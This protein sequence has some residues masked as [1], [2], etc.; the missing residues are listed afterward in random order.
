[1][2]YFIGMVALIVGGSTFAATV[3]ARAA[4]GD[5]K[6]YMVT[7]T[8]VAV[9]ANIIFIPWFWLSVRRFLS[10]Q[11]KMKESYDKGMAALLDK[12]ETLQEKLKDKDDALLKQLNDMDKS[13]S[14]QVQK[15]GDQAAAAHSRLDKFEKKF[16]A[17]TTKV[18]DIEEEDGT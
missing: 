5:V 16:D 10:T 6:P 18:Q 13:I 1:M 4:S 9:I 3:A 17:L 14:L 12:Y 11:D 8:V 2:R 7:V 15:I